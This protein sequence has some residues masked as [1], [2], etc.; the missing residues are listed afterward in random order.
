MAVFKSRALEIVQF[1]DTP[2]IRAQIAIDNPTNDPSKLTVDKLLTEND[3]RAVYDY[4]MT[5]GVSNHAFQLGG[6]NRHD[7][8]S[9]KVKDPGYDTPTLVKKFNHFHCDFLFKEDVSVSQLADVVKHV[10]GKDLP[11]NCI[12]GPTDKSNESCDKK[13]LS[14]LV[15]LVH[16]FK[17]GSGRPAPLP[18]VPADPSD[19]SSGYFF[20]GTSFLSLGS[21]SAPSDITDKSCCTTVY[22]FLDW[23]YDIDSAVMYNCDMRDIIRQ[24]IEYR[25]S[26]SAKAKKRALVESVEA[27][28]NDVA[29]GKIRPYDVY[30][31]V[32]PA[33]YIEACDKNRLKHAI[34]YAYH[35]A[36]EE[37]LA[38]RNLEV[39]HIQ[40]DS[41]SGKTV[42]AKALCEK[43]GLSYCVST[44]G[45]HPFDEYDGQDCL[46][47][48]DFR[49][50]DIQFS[51]LLKILDNN[52]LS[53]LPARYYNRSTRFLKLIIITSVKPVN[54]L[55]TKK[56]EA[57][58]EEYKQLMR[59]IKTSL[60]IRDTKLE[61]HYYNSDKNFHIL[62]RSEKYVFSPDVYFVDAPKPVITIDEI[63]EALRGTFTAPDCDPEPETVPNLET[64]A[65]EILEDSLICQIEHIYPPYKYPAE[66][67][68][69]VA[70]PIPGLFVPTISP[71]GRPWII[72]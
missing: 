59:R 39:I 22:N 11:I 41:G 63:S 6:F 61:Y 57:A 38:N 12:S 49:D 13:I 68:A 56:K 48:D 46:I 14:M 37:E 65:E 9:K 17:P 70:E 10:T 8:D 52:T 27:F 44:P 36:P 21:P 30:N 31:A 71:E 47:L 69:Y 25:K 53:D 7:H 19:L 15:Y 20:D 1:E 54:T 50:S 29:M 43:R 33:V 55:Y 42:M 26:Q 24:F 66:I 34:Q 60:R 18:S 35:H 72:D 4:V 40:G 62:D 58:G 3:I 23:L 16:G 51:Q 2:E 64:I 32:S 5:N 45:A 28:L 67:E